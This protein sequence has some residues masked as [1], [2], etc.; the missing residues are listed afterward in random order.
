MSGDEHESLLGGGSYSSRGRNQA[1][2]S[3]NKP[4]GILLNRIFVLI[5]LAGAVAA[6]VY[7]QS[8]VTT[9]R[10]ELTREE[11]TVQELQE[12]VQLHAQVIQRFNESVTNADVMAHLQSLESELDST[13]DTLEHEMDKLESKVSD[14]LDSTLEELGDTVTQA[15]QE[16]EEQVEKVKK[17]VDQYVVKTQDQFSMENSFMVYQIAGTLT[18]LSCLISMWHMTAHLSK[19]HEPVVQRK[20]LAI[21]WMSPIYA[22]T[23]W[24]SLVFHSAEGYLAIV[25]DGYEAYVIYQVILFFMSDALLILSSSETMVGCCSRTYLPSIASSS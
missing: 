9:L 14:Q 13:Q 22:V 20:I 15:R 3:S 1:S 7:F 21:L 23:S 25:K 17:D 12:Q 16:I 19:M 2:G 11:K 4:L 18:L 10:G 5:V 8:E 6:S 24:F